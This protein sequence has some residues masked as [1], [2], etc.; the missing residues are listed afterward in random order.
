[1]G[2]SSKEVYCVHSY[3]II[4]TIIYSRNLSERVIGIVGIYNH[5]QH[6]KEIRLKDWLELDWLEPSQR[7]LSKKRIQGKIFGDSSLWHRNDG[8]GCNGRFW[9]SQSMSGP[10]LPASGTQEVTCIAIIFASLICFTDSNFKQP[11]RWLE[12]LSKFK[13]VRIP[14]NAVIKVQHVKIKVHFKQSRKFEIYNPPI[15]HPPLPYH[16][17][18]SLPV[19]HDPTKKNALRVYNNSSLQI[20]RR[21][22]ETLKAINNCVQVV[23][24]RSK[25]AAWCIFVMNGDNVIWEDLVKNE[26]WLGCFCQE[27]YID[28]VWY[29][30]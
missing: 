20:N 14:Q 27:F 12:K 16:E 28:I 3:T 5:R 1:M 10:C 19:L 11:S 15:H 26:M 22:Q 25:F 8:P 29:S 4:Y 30:T 17:I 24:L 9:P 21:S 2:G 13:I 6:I 18:P 7:N 23:R